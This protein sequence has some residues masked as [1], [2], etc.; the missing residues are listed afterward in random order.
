VFALVCV[1][2]SLP[3]PLSSYSRVSWARPLYVPTSDSAEKDRATPPCGGKEHPL[4]SPPSQ[5]REGIA[6]LANLVLTS[7]SFRCGQLVSLF[8]RAPFHNP[9][10]IGFTFICFSPMSIFTPP[11]FD[12]LV[13]AVSFRA[14]IF[15]PRF[16][17]SA[18]LLPVSYHL[19][20]KSRRRSSRHSF[21]SSFEQLQASGPSFRCSPV[22]LQMNL[23]DPKYGF[24]PLGLPFY[25]WSSSYYPRVS[26]SAAPS[27]PRFT[28]L[29]PPLLIYFC[30]IIYQA[31]GFF[32]FS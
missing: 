14:S 3:E 32:W 1:C 8:S 12:G 9:G 28:M 24:P 19:W 18:R 6:F 15:I 31:R 23:G 10:R 27:L 11:P 16:D 26:A 21:L 25:E 22:L 5:D 20:K 4:L 17:C 29:F 7:E 13:H 2:V 30:L